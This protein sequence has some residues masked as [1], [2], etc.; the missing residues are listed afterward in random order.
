[1]N[2][3]NG[4]LHERACYASPIH[5]SLSWMI[6]RNGSA[7]G[8][9]SH[10]SPWNCQR[11]STTYPTIICIV[12]TAAVRYKSQ[13]NE[14]QF[15]SNLGTKPRTRWVP[16]SYITSVIWSVSWFDSLLYDIHKNPLHRIDKWTRKLE[17]NDRWSKSRSSKRKRLH[18]SSE[19]S[20]RSSHSAL[21]KIPR[22]EIGGSAARW[23]KP[24]LEIALGLYAGY[25]NL[26]V[27][28]SLFCECGKA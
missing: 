15:P 1:M 27:V 21:L 24:Q 20:T 26:L 17:L 18:R 28:R 25:L 23:R 2:G 6:T 9:R 10:W 8:N 7:V 5:V 19:V 13:Q 22:I 3:F 11:S 4:N 12:C 14:P 16:R